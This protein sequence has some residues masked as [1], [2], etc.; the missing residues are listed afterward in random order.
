MDAQCVGSSPLQSDPCSDTILLDQEDFAFRRRAGEEAVAEV[1]VCG[2]KIYMGEEGSFVAAASLHDGCGPLPARADCFSYNPIRTAGPG[3][4]IDSC[5]D[6][7]HDQ[8]NGAIDKGALNHFAR[9]GIHGLFCHYLPVRDL[10][11]R[12][13]SAR[14]EPLSAE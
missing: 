6:A 10:I 2:A 11:S 13:S 9:E 7:E 4:Q 8:H 5:K 1:L 3:M 14:P 12:Q